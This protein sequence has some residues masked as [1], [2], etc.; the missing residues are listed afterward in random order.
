MTV[1]TRAAPPAWYKAAMM[2]SY[3]DHAGAAAGH[4]AEP[5]RV[6]CRYCLGEGR[7][8]PRSWGQ[9]P[10]ICPSCQGTGEEW[11]YAAQLQSVDRLVPFPK[12][13]RPS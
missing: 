12:A 1:V 5:V 11:I 3:S 7:V 6:A 2:T 9:G 13:E 10:E 8:T 4:M